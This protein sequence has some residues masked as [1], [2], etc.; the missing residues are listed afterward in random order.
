MSSS[1]KILKIIFVVLL[2]V[3]AAELY[4]F[5]LYQPK[6]VNKSGPIT[7]QPPSPTPQT[8]SSEKNQFINENQ[9]VNTNTVNNLFLYKK[10][11]LSSSIINNK[12]E[13]EIVFINK[14]GGF[15]KTE[16][17]KY[18]LEIK[19][20]SDSEEFNTFYYN[21]NE[22]K[23]IKVFNLKN[24]QKEPSNINELKIGDKIVIE[25]SLNL[26]KDPN[27]NLEKLEISVL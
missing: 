20:K 24:N 13:G 27:N 26:L 1:S 3:T 4:Y 2:I 9:A 12:Y 19:I 16:Q 22:V 15:L 17:F 7:N 18:N 6:S 25:E 21:E 10:S 14:N 8:I 5:F 11:I 23:Q